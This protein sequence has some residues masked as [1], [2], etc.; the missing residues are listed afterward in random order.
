[1]PT[2][3]HKRI[4]TI[5]AAHI[6]RIRVYLTVGRPSVCLLHPSTAAA[7]AGGFAAERRRLQWI[8]IDS[9]GRRA[10]GAGA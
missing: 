9:G 2:L 6:L 10:P 1:L 8:L 3:D 4:V 5:D 7:A